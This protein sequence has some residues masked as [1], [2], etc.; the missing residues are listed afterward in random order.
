MSRQAKDLKQLAEL[1]R[2]ISD[3][4]LA[5]LAAIAAARQGAEARRRGLIDG[6]AATRA[7]VVAAVGD[8]ER[9]EPVR[10]QQL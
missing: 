8:G 7:G 10:P 4:D 9:H 3:R 1:A 2:L 5:A 6:L